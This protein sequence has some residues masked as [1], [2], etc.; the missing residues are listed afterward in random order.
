MDT[1]LLKQKFVEFI[2]ANF[3]GS[4][5]NH[6]DEIES[7]TSIVKSVDEM[8]R[9]ALFV[10]LEPQESLESVSD[11]HGD[12]YDEITVE[13]ACRSYNKHS[14]KAGLYHQ[15]IVENDLVEIEQSF[16]T[17]SSF[18][19]ESGVSIK[20]GSWLMW[21]HFPESLDKEDDIIWNNVL[22]GEFTGVSVECSGT[23]ITLDE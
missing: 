23:G 6:K 11:L 18:E 14:M 10:V 21:M 15:S 7:E 8:E 4:K 17:P 3:G 2:D 1:E 20:K 9:R 16:I 19:T 12:Y 13:K 5:E 22:S